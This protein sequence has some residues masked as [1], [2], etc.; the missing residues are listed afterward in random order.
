MDFRDYDHMNTRG[1]EKLTRHLGAF[2]MENYELQDHR[3]EAAY[4]SWNEDYQK[5]LAAVQEELGEE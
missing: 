4:Q 5:Y 1:A 2:L 3:E